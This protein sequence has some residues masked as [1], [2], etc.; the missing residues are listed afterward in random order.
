[1]AIDVRC[2]NC[3]YSFVTSVSSGK[4]LCENC[5]GSRERKQ[6]ERDRWNALTQD[7]KIEEIKAELRQIWQRLD[8]DGRIG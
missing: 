2:A 5:D 7:Q 3:G 4:W 6:A 8:W 1:M